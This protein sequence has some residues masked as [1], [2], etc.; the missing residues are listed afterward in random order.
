MQDKFAIGPVTI[1]QLVGLNTKPRIASAQVDAAVRAADP[2]PPTTLAAAGIGS[3][4]EVK[5]GDTVVTPFNIKAPPMLSLTAPD[6]H[7][8]IAFEGA[9]DRPVS[10]EGDASPQFNFPD[11]LPSN[12]DIAA[13]IA[14]LRNGGSPSAPAPSTPPVAEAPDKIVPINDP[15]PT[16]SVA[17]VA[18]PMVSDAA[19]VVPIASDV[20]GESIDLDAIFDG[21]SA[22]GDDMILDFEAYYAEAGVGA[23]PPS[24]EAVGAAEAQVLLDQHDIFTVDLGGYYII[25]AAGLLSPEPHNLGS[26]NFEAP[27][28]QLSAHDGIVAI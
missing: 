26:N 27:Q 17:D 13:L 23:L 3:E 2:L 25:D 24:A 28:H 19:P 14:T 1:V 4:I 22:F 21:A 18:P 15:V 6:M 5:I 12:I 11:S 9:V 20:E 16:N 8:A 7:S 10:N